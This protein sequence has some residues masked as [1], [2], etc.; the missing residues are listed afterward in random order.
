V[1]SS[2]PAKQ[3]GSGRDEQGRFLPGHCGNPQGRPRGIDIRA[4][5]IKRAS[6]SGR[7]LAAELAEVV[8]ALLEQAKLGDVQAAKL[9]FD[10]LGLEEKHP[11][12]SVDLRDQTGAPTAIDP[13]AAAGPQA[14]DDVILV[15]LLEMTRVGAEL[16]PGCREAKALE[17]SGLMPKPGLH[18]AKT[19]DEIDAAFAELE[20]PDTEADQ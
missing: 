19:P 5:A 10:K 15:T 11:L 14:S 17:L 18:Q 3:A 4:E 12:I 8:D 9:L 13:E 2:H 20:F 6:E 1:S 7:D 16:F